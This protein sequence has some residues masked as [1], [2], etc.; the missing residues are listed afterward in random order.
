MEAGES[1]YILDG[2]NL[3]MRIYRE[4]NRI[5][6]WTNGVSPAKTYIVNTEKAEL[7]CTIDEIYEDDQNYSGYIETYNGE[8]IYDLDGNLIKKDE[9]PSPT[10]LVKIGDVKKAMIQKNLLCNDKANVLLCFLSDGTVCVIVKNGAD[11]EPAKLEYYA[12]S[13]IMLTGGKLFLYTV[14]GYG[15]ISF[16]VN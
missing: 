15:L 2:Y 3:D 1:E 5:V 16:S 9:M 4:R 7:I 8:G 13:A 6:A 14:G 12:E 11:G 10:E